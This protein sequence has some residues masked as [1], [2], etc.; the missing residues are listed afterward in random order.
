VVN[1]RICVNSP[2]LNRNNLGADRCSDESAPCAGW[3]RLLVMP[4]SSHCFPGVL[5]NFNGVFAWNS[6]MVKWLLVHLDRFPSLSTMG[7]VEAGDASPVG[8]ARPVFFGFYPLVLAG[9]RFFTLNHGYL[10]KNE[11]LYETQN[12]CQT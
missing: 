2:H 11:E 5:P 12:P 3:A 9:W 1:L 6:T 4:L 10:S 7:A 8:T